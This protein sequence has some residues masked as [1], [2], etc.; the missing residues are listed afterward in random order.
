MRGFLV[1]ET[2]MYGTWSL[3]LFSMVILVLAL[4]YIL[5]RKKLAP[6]RAM[7]VIRWFH[8]VYG[9]FILA[10]TLFS[11]EE[12]TIHVVRLNPFQEIT[13]KS[14]PQMILNVLLFIPWAF[15]LLHILQRNKNRSLIVFGCGVMLTV[16]I[17]CMQYVFSVG[18]FD[19]ND[20]LMNTIGVGIGWLLRVFCVRRELNADYAGRGETNPSED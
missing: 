18:W 14:A 2:K 3:V 17:E 20:L 16:F 15:S 10:V 9:F 8:V 19:T 12:G 13:A 11:R 7:D 5:I 6:Q 1:S 4:S